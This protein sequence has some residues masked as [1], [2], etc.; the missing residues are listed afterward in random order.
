METFFCV[1]TCPGELLMLLCDNGAPLIS[2]TMK[3]YQGLHISN[4]HA[5]YAYYSSYYKKEIY[6]YIISISPIFTK[7]YS[8]YSLTKFQCTLYISK[9]P[10]S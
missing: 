10:L 3:V 6:I 4:F 9:N 8:Q 5:P 1:R 2:L 7:K